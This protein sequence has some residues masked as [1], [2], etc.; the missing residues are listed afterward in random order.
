M[1]LKSLTL[2]GFKSFADTTTLHL[3]PGITVVV[4][5][6]GS[7]KSNVVDA[8][9]W[10]L[11]AQGPR[12]LRST[13]MDDVIFAG[14]AGRPALGRAEVSLTIDNGSGMLAIDFPEVTISRTLFRNGTSEYALNQVPCRLLDI[15]E[16][17]S[18]S[19]VGRTQHVIVGQGQLDA[20]LEARPEE[21]RA[22][23]E[24]AAGVL[25]YRRR[26]EKAERRLAAT[27]G[28]LVRLADL[29]REARRQ[30]RPLERQ[31]EAAR[32]HA[33]VAAELA[34]LRIHLAGALLASLST[35]RAGL[36]RG[37]SQL[38]DEGAAIRSQLGELDTAVEQAQHRL[39][40][41]GSDDLADVLVRGEAL[42]ARARGLAAVLGERRRSVARERDAVV[43][44]TV[45]ATLEAEAGRLRAELGELEEQADALGPDLEGQAEAEAALAAAWSAFGDGAGGGPPPEASVARTARAELAA[46]QAAVRRCEAEQARSRQRQVTLEQRAALV[47]SERS[48]LAN[49]Q[50]QRRAELAE[51]AALLDPA[52]EALQIAA[53]RLAG[54]EEAWRAAEA[55][56]HRWAAR[57]ETLTL[58]LDEARARAGA[59]R[60]ARVDGVL[61]PLLELVEV[62]LGW[63]AAFEAAAG[64]ALA[65]VVVD[66]GEGAR[67]ALEHL[68]GGGSGAVLGTG[69]EHRRVAAPPVGERVR[70]HVRAPLPE[71]DALVETL[72]GGAVCVEA[73]A[74]SWE[75]ALDV[76]LAHPDAVVVTPEGD[77]FAPDGWRMGAHAGGSSRA[78]L[79]DA[80]ARAA[81][82]VQTAATA[83]GE[84]RRASG[85]LEQA[86]RR[87]VEL[88][89]K[90]TEGASVL[91]AGDDA[92]AR[93]DRAS[94]DLAQQ[95]DDVAAELDH[96]GAE[97]VVE[98]VRVGELETGLPELDAA[99]AREVERRRR[100]AAERAR[101]EARRSALSV[102]RSQL[103]RRAAALDDRRSWLNARL[104]EVE[105]RLAGN[106]ARRAQAEVRRRGLDDR[107]RALDRLTGLLA[108]HQAGL[109]E[110]L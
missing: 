104:A 50:D 15:Q 105:R 11:G 70:A 69:I 107:M 81:G 31:A 102:A 92:L 33:A 27:E 51:L 62:D 40:R 49:R 96:L 18:D 28:N 42:S 26:K 25:K 23:I 32:R 67:R 74:R 10:V 87:S 97:A 39:A 94:A 41:V 60:L 38:Q 22:V 95:L 61:G 1:Y 52:E 73:G 65:A 103:D 37:R 99:E 21:R 106:D 88:A 36:E 3:E 20:V 56:E 98:R 63:E 17:L 110:G 59:E 86:R 6:N 53:D 5:P 89:A 82:A 34:A 109:D 101:L 44:E 54:A 78:A 91:V 43:D 75:A 108:V 85:E 93:L 45:V 84:R 2:K 30:L 29:V 19:G 35:R 14:A 71:V 8:V 47:A 24:E 77:R 83:A 64:Q 66:G 16:L 4:G 55:E 12:S 7:G 80:T 79:D 76:A 72:V 90:V 13:K 57:A 46:A 100:R 9:A 58:A 68:G 48:D